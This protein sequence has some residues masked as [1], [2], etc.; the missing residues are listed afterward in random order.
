MLRLI[1]SRNAG[2][3]ALLPNSIAEVQSAFS[4][5]TVIDPNLTYEDS[6][7]REVQWANVS[8]AY[9]AFLHELGHTFGLPHCADPEGVMSR[10][11]DHFNRRFMLFEPPTRGK[12][13]GKDFTPDQVTRWDTF[14]AA[15]LNWSPWFQADGDNKKPFDRTNPPEIKVE[16]DVVTITSARGIRVAGAEL[17]NKPPFFR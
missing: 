14:Q 1:S 15:Q 4:D 17:D 7:Y 5:T 3:V 11:F 16:G 6:A 13:K 10:G 12:D 8:T 2:G 9:G